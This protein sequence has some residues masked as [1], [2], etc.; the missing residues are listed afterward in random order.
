MR[1]KFLL[2]L[3]LLFGFVAFSQEKATDRMSFSFMGRYGFII[4]HHSSFVYL[5]EDHIKA[6]DFSVNLTTKGDKEW[7][8]LYRIPELGIGLYHANLGNSMYLGKVNAGYG[9]IRIPMIHNK[10][11]KLH[12]SIAGGIAFLSKPFNAESNIYNIAIGSKA[13]AFVDFGI[14]GEFKCFQRLFLVSGIQFTHYSNGAWKKPNLGFNIPSLSAGFKYLIR[15]EEI[16]YKEPEQKRTPDHKIETGIIYLAGVRENAPPNGPKYFVSSISLFAEKP[17]TI[18]RM[19]GAGVDFFWDPSIGQR[20]KKDS[21]GSEPIN[22]FRSGLHV[23]H[24]LVFNKVYFVMQIGGYFYTNDTKGD[25]Y[26]YSRFGLRYKVTNHINANLTLKTH[27]FT[28]DL[29]E[30]GVGYYFIK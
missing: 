12:Y 1:S 3:F 14:K 24:N 5:I 30:F 8:Q 15:N 28:A 17:V 22:N 6:L 19:F 21:K 2:G 23:S 20:L 11:V 4:P 18:K 13:N 16:A 27:R 7:Q 26:L 25:K 29:I 10:S 9:V